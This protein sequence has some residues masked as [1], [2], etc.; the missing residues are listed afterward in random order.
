MEQAFQIKA[1]FLIG[2]QQD[3][4]KIKEEEDHFLKKET[5]GRASKS[6]NYSKDR[7]RNRG[8]GR[9]DFQ[10]RGSS[11]LYCTIYK[12]TDHKT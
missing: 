7:G 5:Y 12:R 6:Q 1:N 8:S 11:N 10:L 9:I 4:I 2:R 3:F